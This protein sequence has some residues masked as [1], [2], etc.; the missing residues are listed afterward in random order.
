MTLR[1]FKRLLIEHA[2]S[3]IPKEY[4]ELIYVPS[5][6]NSMDLVLRNAN[7]DPAKKILR[8]MNQDSVSALISRNETLGGLTQLLS[9]TFPPNDLDVEISQFI[10]PPAEDFLFDEKK[11][12][13]QNMKMVLE[14]PRTSFFQ[15]LQIGREMGFVRNKLVFDTHIPNPLHEEVLKFFLNYRES[16]PNFTYWLREKNVKNRLYEGF[17]FQGNTGYAFVG[18]YRGWSGNFRTKSVG[19]VFWPE[20]DKIGASFE[21]IF[22]GE[23]RENYLQFYSAIV[24]ELEDEYRSAFKK[25][26][27][28]RYQIIFS[29]SDPFGQA[30]IFL[31]RFKPRFDDLATQFSVEEV[32]IPRNE[33]DAKLGRVLEIREKIEEGHIAKPNEEDVSADADDED[34]FE[35]PKSENVS[36]NSNV[37]LQLDDPSLI[38][39][40]GRKPFVDAL[41]EYIKRLWAEKNRNA[42]YTIHINGEWGSGKSTVMGLLKQKLLQQKHLGRSS[43]IVIDFNAWQNQHI[44]EPWWVFLDTVYKGIFKSTFGIKHLSVWL[45]EYWWRIFSMNRVKLIAT[46]ALFLVFGL[47]L[48][49]RYKFPQ[50]NL[51]FGANDKFDLGGIISALSLVG[52]IGLFLSGVINSL[53]PGSE[54]AASRYKQQVRDPMK[55]IKEHFGSILKY[56]SSNVAVFIDDIDRCEPKFVVQLLEGLQTVFRN[57]KVLYVIAGD[58]AWIRQSFEIHYAALKETVVKPGQSLGNFFV[59]K[60]LQQSVHLPPMTPEI[61]R[62]YW[63]KLI[64]G[65]E[66]KTDERDFS[67][68]IKKIDTAIGEKQINEVIQEAKTD[69][70][71][72]ILRQKAA[73]KVSSEK[74]I[75][76]IEHQLLKYHE[77]IEPNPRSMKR[78]VNNLALE[79]ASNFLAG[80]NEKVS[81]DKL[82]R[83]AIL[84]TSFPLVAAEIIKKPASLMAF[85]DEVSNSKT[86]NIL[87]GIEEEDLQHLNG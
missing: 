82:I 63:N 9:F 66:I 44:Q 26:T 50:V 68:S 7:S 24:K 58:A 19:L 73:A 78:L 41:Y 18:L 38:D 67:D 23:D 71:R 2:K 60:T 14:T 51:L 52:T 35:V 75:K 70:E 8:Q 54:E 20:G 11:I 80:L 5:S 39:E 34:S 10:K 57:G 21:M 32:F 48:L 53:I 84:R 49:I 69:D 79:K 31:D 15:F 47:T 17:W 13:Q 46:L 77:L 74:I 83:W 56:T 59:E 76:D 40:L 64:Q 87:L 37:D 25:V 72:T 4:S 27:D 36:E 12:I 30:K 42:A 81:E 86:A 28:S 55:H 29:P 43:W 1:E 61:K 3:L 65:K 62:M 16:N 22:I 45:R 85:K 6:E 33:F